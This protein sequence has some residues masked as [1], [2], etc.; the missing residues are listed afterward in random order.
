M[1][2]D[3]LFDALRSAGWRV[4]N[5][6]IP[7]QDN[8]VMQYAYRRLEGASDCVCND[9][10]PSLCI[11]PSEFEIKGKRLCSAEFDIRGES[12][13]G[14]INFSIYG[15]KYEDVLQNSAKYEAALRL[16]WE[17]VA[18]KTGESA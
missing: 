16:A 4:E 3:E 13:V 1:N 12:S 7:C 15:I 14:W 5:D 6:P 10:P 11:R 9:R 17:S 8:L 18:L 2:S